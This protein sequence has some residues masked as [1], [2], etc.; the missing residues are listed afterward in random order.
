VVLG[1]KVEKIISSSSTDFKTND[2]LKT[3]HKNP[4]LG[5]GGASLSSQLRWEA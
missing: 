3:P 1:G 4:S 5:H 2:G